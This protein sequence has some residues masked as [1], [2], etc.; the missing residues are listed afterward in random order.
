MMRSTIAIIGLEKTGYELAIRL[1]NGPFR[2]LLVDQDSSKALALAEHIWQT[3]PTADV[4]AIDC[5][6]DAS[7][8]ADIIVLAVSESVKKKLVN[9]IR[10]VATCKI[11]ISLLSND[12]QNEYVTIKSSQHLHQW[13]PNSKVVSVWSP[14]GV[15]QSVSDEKGA[16]ACLL[17]THQEAL[18]TVSTLMQVAGLN[19]VVIE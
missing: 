18:A 13:L 3:I 7:W 19:P 17:S 11:V 6:V 5:Q 9:Q 4:E 14:I 10:D 1:V 2:L 8:E 12:S 15:A 16:D